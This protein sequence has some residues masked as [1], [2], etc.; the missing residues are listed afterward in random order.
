MPLIGY[1][2]G[3][4]FASAAQGVDHWIAM[5][6]LVLIGV[7]MIRVALRGDEEAQNSDLGVRTMFILA[8]ATSIDAL[9]VGVSMAFLDVN[10]WCAIAAIGIVTLLLSAVGIYLGHSIGTR[11]GNKAGIVG[12]L[13]LVAIGIKIV[14]EHLVEGI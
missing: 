10:I 11:L 6:L 5:T 12:G 8:V 14:V 3:L 4:A 9:A 13:V 1:F 2:A 7:N